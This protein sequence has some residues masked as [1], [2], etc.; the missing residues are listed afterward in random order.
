MEP[1]FPSPESV[2]ANVPPP[3]LWTA[4]EDIRTKPEYLEKQYRMQRYEA[5][6]PTRHAVAEFRTRPSMMEGDFAYIYNN[7]GNLA[8]IFHINVL[9]I[10]R[11]TFRALF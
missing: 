2:L 9:T 8:V 5:I 10:S 1:E 11:F 7:A 3:L 6:E 4:N